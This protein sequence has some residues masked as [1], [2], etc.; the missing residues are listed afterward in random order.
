MFIREIF[1]EGEVIQ[2]NFP[3]P[4]SNDKFAIHIFTTDSSGRSDWIKPFE[5]RDKHDVSRNI[6]S[7]L[8]KGVKP[9]HIKVEFNGTYINMPEFGITENLRAWFGKGKKGGAGGGGEAGLLA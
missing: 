8:N 7:Q 1:S 2:G 6:Q 5:F 3:S 4:P 9:E